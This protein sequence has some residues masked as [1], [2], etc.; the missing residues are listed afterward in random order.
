MVVSNP[1]DEEA[2]SKGMKDVSF[3]IL[4]TDDTLQDKWGVITAK[5]YLYKNC[6]PKHCKTVFFVSD[7][8]GCFKLKLHKATVRYAI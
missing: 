6:L 2:K 3:V 7:G 4:M 8:A 1:T 5:Q